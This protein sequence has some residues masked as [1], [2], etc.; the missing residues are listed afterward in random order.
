MVGVAQGVIATFARITDG[1]TAVPFGTGAAHGR[2]AARLAS[3][4]GLGAIAA[5]HHTAAGFLAA[6]GPGDLKGSRVG[7]GGCFG[8]AAAGDSEGESSA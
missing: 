6:V 1:F 2:T 7:G 3:G 8:L 5:T 4:A